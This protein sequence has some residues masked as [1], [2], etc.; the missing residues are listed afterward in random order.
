[1][2]SI[3]A[4]YAAHPELYS[5]EHEADHRVEGRLPILDL[6]KPGTVAAELGVYTGLYA[7]AILETVRPAVL[8]LVDPLWLAYGDV[9][10]NWAHTRRAARCPLG[11]PTRPP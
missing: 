7:E 5:A 11:S 1:M 9:Y 8:H 4:L 6:V 3:E 2:T 10:P